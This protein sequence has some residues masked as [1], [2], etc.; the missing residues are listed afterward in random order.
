MA[1]YKIT[2]ALS[3]IYI[4][5]PSLALNFNQQFLDAQTELGVALPTLAQNLQQQFLDAQNEAR[6]EMKVNP[7]IWDDKLAAYAQNYANQRIGDCDLVH[8]DG[9]Y[10][11]NIAWGSGDLSITDAVK[12]WI[13]EKA[14][15]NYN[16][17]T[18]AAGQVCGHYTQ[19]VWRNTVGV[20][21]AKVRCLN[22]GTFIT[23]NYDPPG[24]YIGEKPF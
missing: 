22:G 8:S 1:S 9:P 2:L 18:C 17:N 6:A 21:C 16:S 10:G 13:D 12:M 15:Y 24:N 19:V 3:F 11:E 14:Y 20:G 7:M 5:L 23:C 4:A